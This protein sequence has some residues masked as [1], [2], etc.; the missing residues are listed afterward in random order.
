MI[1][2]SCGISKLPEKVASSLAKH[3]EQRLRDIVQVYQ[4]TSS[5]ACLLMRFP[6]MMAGCVKVHEAQPSRRTDYG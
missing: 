3:V 6:L 4:L 1:A 5:F 2:E